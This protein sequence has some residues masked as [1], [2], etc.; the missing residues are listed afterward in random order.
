MS[1][2]FRTLAA[3]L[4]MAATLFLAAGAV[5]VAPL[6]A[7]T[8][9]G[10]VLDEV[11]ESPVSGA[12]VVLLDRA[13]EERAQALSDDAGNFV[14][15]PPV[16]GE[17]YLAATRIGYQPTRSPLIALRMEGTAPIELMMQPAPI[18]LEGFEVE[19]DAEGRA[20]EELRF[21]G[22]EPR[23]LGQRFV[24][25][26][27]IQA[28]QVKQDVG[29]VLEYQAIGGMRVIRPENLNPGSDDLGLCVSLQRA[30]RGSGMG[31]CAMVV[32]DGVPIRGD[33]ALL[34]DPETVGA[35][36]VLLPVEATTLYGT[37]G[38]RGAL[39]IWTKQGGG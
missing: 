14:L 3:T 11:R 12:L 18:G 2:S 19:V 17:Y 13:G 15:A 8:L 32:L 7:Q 38:A 10:R 33:V 22:V 21:S 39:L 37:M 27:E 6:H 34:L 26:A 25:Q 35:M 16:A 20:A 29:S 24:S 36:A 9:A 1:A 30:R 23:D 5:L 28:V 4:L 31:T